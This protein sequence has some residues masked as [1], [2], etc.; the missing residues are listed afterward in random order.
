MEPDLRDALGA[1]RSLLG[2]QL[3]HV[4]PEGRTAGHIVETEAYTQD[5][6]ASHAFGGPRG[7]NRVM[8]GPAGLI[9]VYFTYGMHYCLNVVTGPAGHGQA[10]LIRALEPTEG[11]ELML[12]RRKTDIA[13]LTN[14]PAKLVQAMGITKEHNG[15]ALGTSLKLIPGIV[16][17]KIITTTRVGISR[18]AGLP[19][20]FYIA[21]NPHVSRP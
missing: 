14:G 11:I 8:F 18:A 3:I 16:P 19:R 1:A 9:Y 15:L 12:H 21:D 17:R 4:S 2:W 7:R 13:R 10:V 20:R 5:D 6:P